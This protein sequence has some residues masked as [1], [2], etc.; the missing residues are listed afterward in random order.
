MRAGILDERDELLE[1]IATS[2]LRLESLRATAQELESLNGYAVEARVGI[3][4]AVDE[5][6]G[7]RQ[8][9]QKA[10]D[11]LETGFVDQL[12]IGECA[13]RGAH[14]RQPARLGEE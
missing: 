7:R 13:D 3:Q 10:I 8:E 14:Q 2:K 12:G 5:L 6:E 4:S 11:E 9:I 1:G